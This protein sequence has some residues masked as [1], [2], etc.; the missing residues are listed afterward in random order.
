MGRDD[1]IIQRF[2][3]SAVPGVGFVQCFSGDKKAN[4]ILYGKAV[5][6]ARRIF[7][8]KSCGIRQS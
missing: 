7:C 6:R 1:I 3:Q 2:A 4:T 5:S 8:I